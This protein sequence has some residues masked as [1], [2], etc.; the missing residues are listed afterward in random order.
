MYIVTGWSEISLDPSLYSNVSLVGSDNFFTPLFWTYKNYI[1]RFCTLMPFEKITIL[2]TWTSVVSKP[3]L[4]LIFLKVS[5][6]I[7]KKTF[8]TVLI[9]LINYKF[10]ER[11]KSRN[12]LL[13]LSF[14]TSVNVIN[15]FLSSLIFRVFF[16]FILHY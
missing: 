16:F 10:V 14:Y 1:K 5:S 12:K 15:H 6:K 8:D 4:L 13:L 3:F 11:N 9:R 2:Y 7:K